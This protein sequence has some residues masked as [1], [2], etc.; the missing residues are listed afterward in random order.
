M[1]NLAGARWK[2]Y[3]LLREKE[4]LDKSILHCTLAIF[5]PPVSRDGFFLS[6][7]FDLFFHLTRALVERSEEFEQHERINYPIEYLR[8]LRGSFDGG[9]VPLCP[10]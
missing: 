8:I 9:T 6:N 1:Y 7:V 2:R 3:R 5:L 4:D 10:H